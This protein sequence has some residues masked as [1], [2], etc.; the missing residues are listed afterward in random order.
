MS[1]QGTPCASPFVLVKKELGLSTASTV[2]YY[3]IVFFYIVCDGGGDIEVGEDA[4]LVFVC[5]SLD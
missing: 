4:Q 3:I 5:V 2:D 1:V